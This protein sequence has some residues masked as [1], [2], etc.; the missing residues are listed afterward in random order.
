M[1]TY[2]WSR[3]NL[4]SIFSGQSLAREFG[5]KGIHVSHTILDGLIETP[6][7]VERFGAAKVEGT[8][9][10]FFCFRDIVILWY[11]H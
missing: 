5:S 7:V 9:S 3:K 1:I 8:V 4:I 10:V 11:R 6:S 2:P